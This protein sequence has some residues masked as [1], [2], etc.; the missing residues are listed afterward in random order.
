MLV[1]LLRVVQSAHSL[2]WIHRDININIKPDNIYLN[3]Y[4]TSSIVLN[5]WSSAA[6]CSLLVQTWHVLMLAHVSSVTDLLLCYTHLI[7]NW[8]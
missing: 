1:T 2:N 6:R 8:I 3:Y 5:D 4:D 7:S